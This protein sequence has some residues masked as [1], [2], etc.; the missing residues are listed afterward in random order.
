MNKLMAQIIKFG[1]VGGICFLIDFVISTGIFHFLQSVID[2]NIASGIS[3]AVGFVISVV[4]NYI[5]SMKFVFDRRD[6]MSKKK[7]FVV[8]VVLS[9]GGLIINEIIILICSS[10]H[11]GSEWLMANIGVTIWFAFS[12]VI[13]TAIVMVYN[14]ISRKIFLEKK[15]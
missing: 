3:A 7:E 15:N 11:S 1:F 6:D 10:V 5:L 12:K 8:F 13:A 4:V 9:I 14:F 2:K